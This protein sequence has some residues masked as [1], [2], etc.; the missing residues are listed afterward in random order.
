MFRTRQSLSKHPQ[1]GVYKD[2]A[3]VTPKNRKRSDR[4][5]PKPLTQPD[6]F[7][8]AP[9]KRRRDAEED[10]KVEEGEIRSLKKVKV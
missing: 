2:E 10:E 9:A 6:I 8:L 1:F 4:D 7:G 3:V 5:T